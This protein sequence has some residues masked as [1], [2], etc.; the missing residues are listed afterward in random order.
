M[1]IYSLRRSLPK[2]RLWQRLLLQ[3]IPESETTLMTPLTY[4]VFHPTAPQASTEAR[5]RSTKQSRTGPSNKSITGK[6][7]EQN[8]KKEL[9][10]AGKI[11]FCLIAWK[12]ITHEWRMVT[13]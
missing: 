1:L 10:P 9:V 2:T 13:S 5:D 12:G 11:R 6:P 8:T 3:G 7:V 4:A